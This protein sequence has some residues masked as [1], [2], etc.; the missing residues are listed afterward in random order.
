MAFAGFLK[1]NAP[2]D[3]NFSMIFLPR[4]Q[5]FQT[6][7]VPGGGDFAHLKKFPRVL[8]RGGGMVRLEIN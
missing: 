1:I 8:P 5:G 2:G 7:F 3:G 4:G 6:F